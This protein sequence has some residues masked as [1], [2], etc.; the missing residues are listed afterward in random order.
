MAQ[1]TMTE[2]DFVGTLRAV[3]K[4]KLTGAQVEVEQI[5]GQRY[6]FSVVW[7]RFDRMGHPER[8]ERVWAIAESAL[9]P[10]DLLNVG[11]ILTLGRK[12]LPAR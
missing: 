5:R 8:Q 6:R 3:L 4:R 12:D 1:R 11:M 9:E 10:G 7:D 2:P